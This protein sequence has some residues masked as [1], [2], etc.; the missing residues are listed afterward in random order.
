MAPKVQFEGGAQGSC[1]WG[2]CGGGVGAIKDDS[3]VG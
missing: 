3:D 1:L 2:G